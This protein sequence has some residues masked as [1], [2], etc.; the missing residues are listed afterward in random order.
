M[1]D[2]RTTPDPGLVTLNEPA[3]VAVPVA[4]LLRTPGGPRDRQLMLGAG[5]TVLHRT[6]GHALVRATADG[7]CG[8]LPDAAIGPA[9]TPTHQVTTR[10][11]HAYA[12]PDIKSPETMVLSFGSR[13]TALSETAVFIETSHGFVPRQ[14]VHQAGVL[15][16]DPASVAAIFEGTPYLWG[17]NTGSG[18][19]CSGL[20]QAACLSCGI[21]CPGDSDQQQ[22]WLGTLLPEGTPPQRNDLLFWKGHVALVT[23]DATL[24][25]ANA[26]HMLVRFEPTD[27][28]I[29]RI[30]AQ[31]GG[32]VTAHKRL[33]APA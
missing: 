33:P 3:A 27:D 24:I 30:M 16:S 1:T 17:G 26:G 22:A 32:P 25:H 2:P 19:D 23:D 7:Y 8:Y 12:R 4:D 5:V 11:A 20:V 18:I 31:D 28:A 13:L 29:A 6:D 14:Q 21:D 15:A 10:L 9:T